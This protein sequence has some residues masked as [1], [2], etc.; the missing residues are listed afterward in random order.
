MAV[1]SNTEATDSEIL[2]ADQE[3]SG[4]TFKVWTFAIKDD[5]KNIYEWQ[6]TSENLLNSSTV[7]WVQVSTYIKNYLTA[8]AKADGSG[9]YTG[10]TKIT[11]TNVVR[12]RNVVGGLIK[13]NPGDT[14]VAGSVYHTQL[15]ED[16]D[17]ASSSGSVNYQTST[18]TASDTTPSIKVSG[19]II[20]SWNTDTGTLTI[21]MFDDSVAGT[22]IRVFSKGA[23]TFDVTGTNLKGGSTD[24]VTASGDVTCWYSDGTYWYLENFYDDSANLTGGH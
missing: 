22:K 18:F 24:L 14:P 13:Q 1:F 11:S 3:V 10:V 17:D 20:P 12:D 5:K 21:T 16:T 19:Q 9:S 8:G 2:R 6:D 15:L 23:I 7:T 4:S